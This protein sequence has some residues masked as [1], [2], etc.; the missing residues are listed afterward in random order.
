MCL[1]LLYEYRPNIVSSVIL[2]LKTDDKHKQVIEFSY[3]D[4]FQPKIDRESF[5]A[6]NATVAGN[7]EVRL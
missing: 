4:D 5:V 2:L 1:V 3:I 7:V 6:P